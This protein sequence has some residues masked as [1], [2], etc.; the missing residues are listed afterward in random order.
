[1]SATRPW[2]LVT[3]GGKRL[4]R[5]LVDEAAAAGFAVAVHVRRSL[6]EGEAAVAVL[7]AAGVPACV[8]RAD[9]A[10]PDAAERLIRELATAGRAPSLLVN[11][12]ACFH[13][14]RLASVTAA[15]FDA[16]VAVNLRA[17]LLAIKAF[18]EH[19]PTGAAGL[20]VNLVDQR[21]SRPDP[22]YLSYGL[23]KTALWALTRS[24]A[25]ELAPRVRVNAIAPGLVIPDEAMD[26]ARA[27]RIVGRFPLRRG[28]TVEEIR[29]ALGY[30]IRSPSVTGQLLTVDGGAHLGRA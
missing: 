13:H 23:T 5:A 19:L 8:V 7:E 4:G 10:E 25:L 21:I 26:E 9:L 3:G 27:A 24:L 6:R 16:Q 1:V 20:V 14:D 11:S 22:N 15:G 29:A 12:A 2:A 17:P 30:L 18:V 28:G